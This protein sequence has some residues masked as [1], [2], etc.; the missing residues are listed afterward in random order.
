MVRHWRGTNSILQLWHWSI[1]AHKTSLRRKKDFMRKTSPSSYWI[2]KDWTLWRITKLDLPCYVWVSFYIVTCCGDT[3]YLTVQYSCL[4][5]RQ[6]RLDAL[7]YLH[8]PKAGTAIN[9]F[10]HDYFHC[11][12]EDEVSPSPDP[13]PRWL[14]TVSMQLTTEYR[15]K[16]SAPHWYMSSVQAEEQ[17]EGLCGGRLFSCMGH[18]VNP[19]L[20]ALVVDSE[21]NLIVFLR[22]PWV[23][24]QSDFHYSTS[25]P[26]SGHLGPNMDL[27]R[28]VASSGSA[29]EYALYPGIAN[30]ATKVCIVL[31]D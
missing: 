15:S 22:S 19:L 4:F 30:C 17:R 31:Y 9:W 29:M 6:E 10:L 3:A 11:S 27:K 14:E 7:Q 26:S 28:A 5:P 25:R 2:K 20:P 24:I 12:G 13:C 1:G 21:A 18:S 16:E 8:I 23:R